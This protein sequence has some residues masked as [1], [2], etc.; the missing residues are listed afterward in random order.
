LVTDAQ[1]AFYLHVDDGVFAGGTEARSNHL[2]HQAAD[3]LEGAGFVVTDRSECATLQKIVGYDIVQHPAR[4]QMAGTKAVY[5]KQAGEW[6]VASRYVDTS[7]LRAWLGVW[8]WGALLRRECLSAAFHIFKFLEVFDGDTVRWW[9]SVRLE[10]LVM[11]ALI[12]MLFAD[13]SS[14]PAPVIFASDAQ[15]AGEI[16]DS[17]C[18]GYGI[19]D[20]C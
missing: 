14:P 7:A 11:T 9:E 3:A 4:L 15:G 18:G 12:P 2:M 1:S 8:I 16:A 5:L 10:V 17:D 20:A 19:V 13:M 6:F